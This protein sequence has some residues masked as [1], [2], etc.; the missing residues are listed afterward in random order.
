MWDRLAADRVDKYIA[1]SRFVAKRIKKYYKQESTVIYPP[2]ETEQFKIADQVGDYF[3]IGG[4]LA[5]YKRVDIV[6]E[7]V[8]KTG[9]KLKVYGDGIDLERLKKIAKGYAN[10]EFLGWV[11][12]TAKANLYS[13][14]LAFIY[15]Q[16]ED[17][18]ITAVEAQASGR[19][20]IAYRSG[21][22]IETV[23]D[24][25]TGIFFSEQTVDS[26]AEALNN[27]DNAKFN[28]E[29]IKQHAEKFSVAKFKNEISEFINREYE[30][31]KVDNN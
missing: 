10:I 7:A 21:G 30:K 28:P 22:A 3:L 5:P 12:D 8:K 9:K 14:C 2:V 15:P 27:F 20:V 11:D 19:P 17:F 29:I 31:F 18:G 25:E 1:N 23:R 4:R 24:G 16:E 26:L 13:H 6:I